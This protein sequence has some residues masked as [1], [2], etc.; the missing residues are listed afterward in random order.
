[1]SFSADNSNIPTH[2]VQCRKI[3]VF[4]KDLHRMQTNNWKHW[5]QIL[6]LSVYLR[7][8]RYLVC[9]SQE[10]CKSDYFVHLIYPAASS[11]VLG[12]TCDEC[13]IMDF[14]ILQIAIVGQD[15]HSVY[16]E[17]LHQACGGLVDDYH[18]KGNLFSPQTYYILATATESLPGV[19]A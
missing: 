4:F 8:R 5:S 19:P 10:K 16:S 7:A 18:I 11:A 13:L 14:H 3:H 9:L 12:Y 15:F 6:S 1:M 2:R 17:T